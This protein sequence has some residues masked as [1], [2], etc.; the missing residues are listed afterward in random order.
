M[1]IKGGSM[2]LEEIAAYRK[3]VKQNHPGKELVGI[4]IDGPDVVLEMRSVPFDRIRRITGYLVGSMD[5][6]NAAKRA[7]EQERV[8]HGTLP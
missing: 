6:W 3:H 7:E 8:R 2:S 1:K 4:E 5:K